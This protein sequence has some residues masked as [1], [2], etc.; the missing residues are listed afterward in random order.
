M[1]PGVKSAA[2]NNRPI[3]CLEVPGADGCRPHLVSFAPRRSRGDLHFGLPHRDFHPGQAVA[4]GNGRDARLLREAALQ[5]RVRTLAPRGER[6]VGLFRETG[7]TIELDPD[8]EVFLCRETLAEHAIA[9][10]FRRNPHRRREHDH[11][12]RHLADHRRYHTRPNRSVEPPLP[13]FRSCACTREPVAL[14]AGNTP[15]IAAP[16]TARPTA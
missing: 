5:P 15:S 10:P 9:N 4:E 11:R 2:G 6:G 3:E 12:Q 16:A 8:G 1:V 7:I 14:S 13:R